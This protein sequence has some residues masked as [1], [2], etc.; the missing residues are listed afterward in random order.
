[1]MFKLPKLS[2]EDEMVKS[3][4]G[5]EQLN[6]LKKYSNVGTI[7]EFSNYEGRRKMFPF[8]ISNYNKIIYLQHFSKIM[9]LKDWEELYEPYRYSYYFNQ[10]WSSEH[11]SLFMESVLS[12]G[13]KIAFFVPP[14]IKTYTE[15]GRKYYVTNHELEI[16]AEH[17][18]S[19]QDHYFIF[20]LY[21]LISKEDKDN[22]L[23]FYSKNNFNEF[24]SIEELTRWTVREIIY[25]YKKYMEEKDLN[26][27]ILD[28]VNEWK[29]KR[30]EYKLVCFQKAFKGLFSQD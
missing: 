2:L 10:T 25:N 22:I 21:S 23:N 11:T 5:E 29:R 19:L 4:L 26:E 9:E 1:M 8:G 28:I 24:G 27:V 15:N 14:N 16:L 6:T 18:G 30:E 12:K 17:T 3:E 13:A 20:G 7:Y